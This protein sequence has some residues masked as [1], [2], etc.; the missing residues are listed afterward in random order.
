[1]RAHGTR[2]RFYQGCRCPPCRKAW[3]KYNYARIKARR[4]GDWRGLVSLD[5]VKKHIEHLGNHEATARIAGI[6]RTV[7][8]KIING[9]I[10]AVRKST[11]EAILSV[12]KRDIQKLWPI[13]ADDW[14]YLPARPTQLMMADLRRSG[15]SGHA[16]GRRVS[17]KSGLRLAGKK[18]VRAFNARRVEKIYREAG[19]AA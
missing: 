13:L 16:L 2:Q 3:N 7:I 12:T 17:L 6:H 9:N 11:E 18:H 5:A 8:T 4:S 10:S 19:V 15:F 14:S 1:M